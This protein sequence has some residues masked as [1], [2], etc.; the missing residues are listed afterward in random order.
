LTGDLFFNLAVAGSRGFSD[1]PLLKEEVESFILNFAPGRRVRI[2]SGHARGA[3]RL[4]EKLAV[5]KGY[6][7]LIF[8]ADWDTH[9][10]AAGPIRNSE[11]IKKADGLIAFWN[12][13][14]RGTSDS[15]KKA[16]ERGIPVRAVKYVDYSA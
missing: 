8:P 9:G 12:G 15:I 5:E 11:M 7:L 13:R 1:Y 3:D 4:G 6:E 16:E 2:L 10:R 14:S